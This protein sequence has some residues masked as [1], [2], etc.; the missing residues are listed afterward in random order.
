MSI[1]LK[2]LV[3]IMYH[4]FFTRMVYFSSP[5]G[6]TSPSILTAY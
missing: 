5:I 4:N 6:V 1:K 2:R 3:F